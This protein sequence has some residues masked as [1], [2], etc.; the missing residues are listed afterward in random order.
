[1]IHNGSGGFAAVVTPAC[2]C[3]SD[4]NNTR[5]SSPA[6]SLNS[7][8]AAGQLNGPAIHARLDQSRVGAAGDRVHRVRSCPARTTSP[9]WYAERRQLLAEL[10]PGAAGLM[11][12]AVVCNVAVR[13]RPSSSGTGPSRNL[14]SFTRDR[15]LRRSPTATGRD[16]DGSRSRRLCSA[17]PVQVYDN[18]RRGF[19]DEKD[20][21]SK[22]CCG[23]GG[24]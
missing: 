3:G 24:R 15:L 20:F 5:T 11:I 16:P 9:R 2:A 13:R 14:P 8:P 23:W 21:V 18:E 19:V 17:P 10:G 6:P 7:C 22:N 12:W 1:M 4:A